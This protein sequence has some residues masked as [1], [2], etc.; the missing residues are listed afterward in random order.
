M[1]NLKK[2]ITIFMVTVMALG[3]CAMHVPAA[4]AAAT[5]YDMEQ[6]DVDGEGKKK[7]PKG[8]TIEA[9][10]GAVI[11]CEE[12]EI[13]GNKTQKMKIYHE[14]ETTTKV[15]VHVLDDNEPTL[16]IS[17]YWSF[18]LGEDFKGTGLKLY[19]MRGEKR[20]TDYFKD[21]SYTW[22]RKMMV[23]HGGYGYYSD[24]VAEFTGEG[25]VYLDDVSWEL[26]RI[27]NGDFEGLCGDGHLAGVQP[28]VNG[29]TTIT[30][31]TDTTVFWSFTGGAI[32]SKKRYGDENAPGTLGTGAYFVETPDG[33]YIEIV[34]YTRREKLKYIAPTAVPQ[35]ATDL[36][37]G[38]NYVVRVSYM[39]SN[40][41]NGFGFSTER[42]FRSPYQV[43]TN[44]SLT[45][46]EK[47]IYTLFDSYFA[48]NASNLEKRQPLLYFHPHNGAGY[49]RFDNIRLEEA[50]E[51]CTLTNEDGTPVEA[52]EN[53][54]KVNI[55]YQKPLFDGTKDTFE[56]YN[57][58]GV[59]GKTSKEKVAVFTALYDV[60]N[61][62]KPKLREIDV[63]GELAAKALFT[64][65]AEAKSSY[66][67]L[68]F[69]PAMYKMEECFEIPAEGKYMIKVF[70][71][72]SVG[73]LKPMGEDVYTFGMKTE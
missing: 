45:M 65:Y 26:S 50:Q 73:G 19:S 11:T 25:T 20:Q 48:E 58:A 32:T 36:I 37:T 52:L 67:T 71:M 38:K 34:N 35:G 15:M 18:Y 6:W 12:A 41:T 61:A 24:Y 2:I 55:S 46:E 31:G 56:T 8:F 9:G 72:D 27:I 21:N 1:R 69:L 17:V 63:C 7:N 44:A 28:I 39:N 60:T 5:S 43:H 64:G 53:G 54:K 33:N 59:N 22:W 23:Y 51:N 3:T 49:V 68:G 70:T 62:D 57:E 40:N 4:S 13:A 66:D 10:D 42:G 47:A 29:D 16:P 14:K 30:G